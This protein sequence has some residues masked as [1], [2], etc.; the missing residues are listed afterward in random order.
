VSNHTDAKGGT[1]QQDH[2]VDILQKLDLIKAIIKNIFVI[3][4]YFNT[5]ISSCVPG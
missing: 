3:F 5:H 1:C 4:Y 2:A